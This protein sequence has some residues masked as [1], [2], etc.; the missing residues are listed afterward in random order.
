ML[1]ISTE[2]MLNT[3][4]NSRKIRGIMR[5]EAVFCEKLLFFERRLEVLDATAR[6][7]YAIL[8][9]YSLY[10]RLDSSY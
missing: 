9:I 5:Q 2:V 7:F 10:L 6:R 4:I 3:P 1:A 8:S